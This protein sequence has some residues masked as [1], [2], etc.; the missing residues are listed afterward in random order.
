[1][2]RAI[3]L[4]LPIT[5]LALVGSSCG[6][7]DE[8]V[9]IYEPWARPTAAAQDT[10]AVYFTIVAAE[11]DSLIG[12]SVSSG[13]AG[14]AALHETSMD[15]AGV[16]MMSMVPDIE[17]PADGEVVFA[18]GG[19]HVMMRDLVEPLLDGAS[20]EMTL[21]FAQAGDITVEVDVRDQ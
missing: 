17:V 2:P 18:P 19:F 21:V 12:V 20:F 15:E 5:V 7:D 6:G 8:G 10:G 11:E 9:S 16:M 14:S 4:L 3:R 13:V 1:M